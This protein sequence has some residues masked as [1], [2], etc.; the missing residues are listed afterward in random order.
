M[1][2]IR[3]RDAREIATTSWHEVAKHQSGLTAA[4]FPENDVA[5]AQK[6]N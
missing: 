1:M 6:Q 4:L 3:R 5:N 2:L